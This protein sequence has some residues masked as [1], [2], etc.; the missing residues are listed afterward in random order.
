VNT[1]VIAGLL[2]VMVL[3]L[4][5]LRSALRGWARSR[6]T[7]QLLDQEWGKSIGNLKSA[8][9]ALKKASADLGVLEAQ[10]AQARAEVERTRTQCRALVSEYD[11]TKGFL[12]GNIALAGEW[13]RAELDATIAGPGVQHG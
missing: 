11:R 3:I 7:V 2:L 8:T 13:L 12:D 9:A 4:V 10:L 6:Q 5:A 1:I